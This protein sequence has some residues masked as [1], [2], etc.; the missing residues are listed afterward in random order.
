MTL[1]YIPN[2]MSPNNHLSKLFWKKWKSY[3]AR[4]GYNLV[5]GTF[6]SIIS[7]N[8]VASVYFPRA[9]RIPDQSSTD[10]KLLVTHEP[11]SNRRALLE[12]QCKG[13]FPLYNYVEVLHF[14]SVTYIEADDHDLTG[15]LNLIFN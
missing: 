11:R 13:F 3:K 9:I 4:K 1:Q 10:I 8:G 6:T 5:V 2:D 15:R 7:D 14:I 12:R